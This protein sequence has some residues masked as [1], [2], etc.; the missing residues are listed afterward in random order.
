MQSVPAAEVLDALYD[1]A[2]ESGRTGHRG[3]IKLMT[4]HGAKG[5]EFKHVIVLDC[6]DWRWSGEDERRL[7]YVAMTRAQESLTLMRA[8]GGRNPYLVDLGTVDGVVDLLPTVRPEHRR[9]IARRYVALGPAD[10]DIGFAGRR[11]PGDPLHA[12]IE[13]L[14]WG[15]EIVIRGREILSVDDGVVGRLARRTEPRP[16]ATMGTVSGILA[17]TRKQSAP[18]F[19]T[20]LNADRWETVLVELIVESDE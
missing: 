2:S 7:L 16:E 11:G 12:R 8:E 14:R 20:T 3:A 18:E 1:C 13:S 9:D 17:M 10:V 19:Q 4:A 15:A 5:L 6:A